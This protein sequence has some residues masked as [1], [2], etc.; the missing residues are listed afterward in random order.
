[1]DNPL[2]QAR[3]IRLTPYDTW[4][5]PQVD[6]S[7]GFLIWPTLACLAISLAFMAVATAL[8]WPVPELAFISDNTPVTWPSSAQ[9]WTLV[10]LCLRL[11]VDRT[12]PVAMG[13]WLV[14]AMTALAFDEQF[15]LHEQW[16]YGCHVWLNACQHRWVTEVPI[17]LIGVFG[18]LSVVV[19]QHRMPNTT[20]KA[21]L[22]SALFMGGLA[23]CLD[24]TGWPRQ[25][26]PYEEGLEVIAE[27]LFA[28]TLL[29]WTR[30]SGIQVHSP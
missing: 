21:V 26:A 20:A 12:L 27:A 3:I 18:T 6:N 19:L 14:L 23:I 8:Y 11:V 5:V 1:M 4:P 22:W 28:G 9:L 10:L 13:V 15:M 16:K 30:P 24:L 17:L 2:R 7:A 29:G 25:M